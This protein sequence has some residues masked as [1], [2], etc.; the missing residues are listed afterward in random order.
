MAYLKS[1]NELGVTDIGPY[2]TEIMPSTDFL[3]LGMYGTTKVSVEY[4]PWTRKAPGMCVV[5]F[6]GGGRMIIR[7]T[8][9]AQYRKKNNGED[10][11]SLLH[12]KV[13]KSL[14]NGDIKADFYLLT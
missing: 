2:P 4:R 10:A 11:G 6:A 1:L 5:C 7:L 8:T 14:T 12:G 3:Y 9:T 13:I